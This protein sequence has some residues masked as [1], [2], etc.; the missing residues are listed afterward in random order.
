M[1]TI[2]QTTA[3]TATSASSSSDAKPPAE[4]AKDLI[5][6]NTGPRGRFYGEMLRDLDALIAKDPVLGAAVEKEVAA[7]L[8]PVGYAKLLAASYTVKGSDG[9]VLS[10]ARNAPSIEAY[11]KGT[12]HP[13][14]KASDLAHYAR[15]DKLF[16]DGNPRTFD[17]EK[18]QAGITDM[19]SKG[20][21]LEQYEAMAGAAKAAPAGP[22]ALTVAADLTQMTLD[23]IGIF[24][25]TGISD[26]AN[27][28]IS[29]GR[30][31]WVGAG[32]SALA[33]IPVVGALANAGKLGKWAST[34][35][36]AVEL[37]AKNPAARQALEPLLRKLNDALGAIPDAAMKA[38]PDSF[39]QTLEGIKGKL[40]DFFK[41]ADRVF[42]DGVK[43]VADRLGI[44]PEKVQAILD[45]P[46]PSQP[47][48]VGRPDPST[49]M[50]SEAIAKHLDLFDSGAVRI[51]ASAPTGK[52]GRTETWVMP[53]QF[54]DDAIAKSGGD[55]RKLEQLLG[56]DSGTLGSAPVRI[57]IPNP[58]GTRVPSGNEFGANDF[59]RP[60]GYTHPGG[61]PEA[62]ID[63]VSA[64]SYT[65]KNVFN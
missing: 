8:K 51:Q 30:G 25:Q 19:L 6:E 58:S 57:D 34:I 31:D 7:Q 10:F 35:S 49:Y 27:A 39:R 41:V 54:V 64:G 56:L 43:T 14:A 47:G 40:D 9:N 5:A 38:L 29:L 60:G 24:D 18:I 48:G 36:N 3:A 61:I 20:M 63:P 42:S 4:I 45:T 32:L 44:P 26:G 12:A 65:T 52:I 50:S 28:L 53:K 59:W 33:I 13:G 17:G 46:K 37:A 15:L 21:T 55:P 1:T 62:V 11:Y 23:I 22:D 16:G 2:G